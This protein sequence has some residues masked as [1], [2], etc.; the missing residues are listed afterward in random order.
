MLLSLVYQPNIFDQVNTRK[1]KRVDTGQCAEQFPQL[2][3]LS[4]RTGLGHAAGKSNSREKSD[5][6]MLKLE[7]SQR[8]DD[9]TFL[10]SLNIT[11]KVAVSPEN[12]YTESEADIFVA[13]LSHKYRE[14][15]R[16]K[17]GGY[18]TD[19]E[20]DRLLEAEVSKEVSKKDAEISKKDAVISKKDAE[21]SKL[22]ALLVQG[23]SQP[24]ALASD[25]QEAL[26]SDCQEAS[27]SQVEASDSQESSDSQ[28]EMFT[29]RCVAHT[30]DMEDSFWQDIISPLIEL[31]SQ[32]N[33]TSG[34]TYGLVLLNAIFVKE[35]LP[36]HCTA[37]G[38][39]DK[40]SLVHY[41]LLLADGSKVEYT[42][43]ADILAHQTYP[44]TY[45]RTE[46]RGRCARE[47]RLRACCEIQ[48]TLHNNKR[49]CYS[50]A[51]ICAVGYLAKT[52]TV[53]QTT[54]IMPSVAFYK[55]R[56]ASICLAELDG[57]DCRSGSIG[58]VT[59]KPVGNPLPF[60]LTDREQFQE[61][62][63]TLVATVRKALF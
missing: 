41:Q 48:S 45:P 2:I 53:Y 37:I 7:P 30:S 54:G 3:S 28:E 36:I 15:D 4:T 16:L 22:K 31:S 61:F 63:R 47:H 26:A 19:I 33:C 58:K 8:K 57:A 25:C 52:K 49:G 5:L 42:G 56:S 21:I 39:G 1:R 29:C 34:L 51:A 6:S 12:I 40:D 23:N 18:F 9:A 50:Q 14:S 44:R 38:G 11:A 35:K 55:D 27:G 13:A 46:V 60:A 32:L 10:S 43:F 20:W 24:L 59:Y 62:S 17:L